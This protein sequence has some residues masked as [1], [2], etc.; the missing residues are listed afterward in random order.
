MARG[1]SFRRLSLHC[2]YYFP[3]PAYKGVRLLLS[4]YTRP[5]I[6]SLPLLF[7]LISAPLEYKGSRLF[8]SPYTRPLIAITLLCGRNSGVQSVFAVNVYI[9]RAFYFNSISF[10]FVMMCSSALVHN[11]PALSNVSVP[12]TSTSC[13]TTWYP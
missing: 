4:P 3:P 11:S 8:F 12:I 10:I 9:P 13:A 7:R 1:V 5:A 2:R 6:P